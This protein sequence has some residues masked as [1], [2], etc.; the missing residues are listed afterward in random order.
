MSRHNLADFLAE[1]NPNEEHPVTEINV[2]Q[3][4]PSPFI[5]IRHGDKTVIV[6]PLGLG[7]HLSVDI[8]SFVAGE[9]ATAGVFGMSEG[10]RWALPETGTT[11][12]KWN[13]AA[14]VAVLV[15]EQATKP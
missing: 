9:D 8:H 5:I 4:G 7:D 10:K 13:S 6:N 2:T 12:H 11:S 1:Y 3:E 15:G 14:L